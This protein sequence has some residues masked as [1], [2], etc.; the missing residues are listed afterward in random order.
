MSVVLMQRHQ[1]FPQHVRA[2][3]A[4]VADGSRVAPSAFRE[5]V[6]DGSVLPHGGASGVRGASARWGTAPGLPTAEEASGLVNSVD[7]FL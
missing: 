2:R 4:C 7:G 6:H 1:Y 3:G 5:C